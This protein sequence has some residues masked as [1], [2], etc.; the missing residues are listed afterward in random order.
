MDN[1]K[2][3]RQFLIENSDL[4]RHFFHEHPNDTIKVPTP[5][6]VFREHE[7]INNAFKGL[8]LKYFR[9]FVVALMNVD[10]TD[11]AGGWYLYIRPEDLNPYIARCK[12]TDDENVLDIDKTIFYLGSTDEEKEMNKDI[13]AYIKA[14]VQAFYHTKEENNNGNG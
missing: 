5:H 14:G 6:L 11:E 3:I 9:S 2:N 8:S 1:V 10:I 7:E 13:L 4:V 12:I